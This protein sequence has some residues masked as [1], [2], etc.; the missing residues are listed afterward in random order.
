MIKGLKSK[1]MENEIKTTE[2]VTSGYNS[3]SI[4]QF[5]SGYNS[6][7]WDTLL[8]KTT[9]LEHELDRCL[10]SCLDQELRVQLLER[11]TYDGVLLWKIDDF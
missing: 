2:S 10:S 9:A 7:K 1:L 3:L 4:L 5:S 11:A 6:Q 8:T